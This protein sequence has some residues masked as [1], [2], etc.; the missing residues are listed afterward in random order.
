MQSVP[1]INNPSKIINLRKHN[2]YGQLSKVYNI[3]RTTFPHLLATLF[4][5][6][7]LKTDNS[8]RNLLTPFE[9]GKIVEHLSSREG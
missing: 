7:L 3:P 2:T 1:S 5:L 4:N 8:L 6:R 9:V